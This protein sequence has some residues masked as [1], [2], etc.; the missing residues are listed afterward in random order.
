[1]PFV[2]SAGHNAEEP[3][4]V[5]AQA[6]L[7]QLRLIRL[8]Q[9]VSD[10]LDPALRPE[11]IFTQ[12]QAQEGGRLY[13]EGGEGDCGLFRDEIAAQVQR[14]DV[15]VLQSGSRE[16]DDRAGTERASSELNRSRVWGVLL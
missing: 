5:S 10:V 11:A 13:D 1:M 8:Q 15:L 4:P 6:D 14:R 7:P 3:D 9:G 2:Q 16:A 12:F